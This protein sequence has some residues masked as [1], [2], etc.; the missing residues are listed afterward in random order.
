MM[1]ATFRCVNFSAE[2]VKKFIPVAVF[3]KMPNRMLLAWDAVIYFVIFK[4]K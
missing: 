4:K 3:V 1:S 2:I